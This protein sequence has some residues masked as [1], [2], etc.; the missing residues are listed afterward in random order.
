MSKEKILLVQLFSNGDCLLVTTIARQIRI[1]YPNCELTWVVSSKC[2]SMLLNNPDVD[3][4]DEVTIPDTSQNEVVFEKIVQEAMIKKQ[5]GI[6][7]QVIVPQLLGSNMKFYDGVVCTSLYRSSGL[8]ITVDTKPVLILADEEKAKARQFADQHNL[9]SYKN[10]V[11]FECAPQTNQ[12]L[13]TDDIILNYSQQIVKNQNTCII[14]SA[15][16]AY[17]FQQPHI[18]DGNSLSIRETVALTHFCTLLLGCSSGIS[19]AAT[20]SAAKS[21]PMVQILAPDAYYFNP[22]SLTFKKLKRDIDEILEL[23]DFDS[24]SLSAVF[25]DIFTNGF[26][27]AKAKYHQ[28]VTIQF[29]LFRGIVHKFLKEGKFSEIITFVRVNWKEHGFNLSMLKYMFL[30]FILFPFQ[31][32]IDKMKKQ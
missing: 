21:L 7:D 29:K 30:G 3:V 27:Q 16:K 9:A 13:L 17:H 5:E 14:L 24:V 1:N 18:I 32:V 6:Y 26:N 28:Q 12:L 22:L 8:A 11:L 10:V 23:I 4:I 19:L 15:P 20:S 25:T 31:L 2:K